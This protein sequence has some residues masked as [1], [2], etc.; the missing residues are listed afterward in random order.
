M[1]TLKKFSNS[2]KDLMS[3]NKQLEM[4]AFLGNHSGTVKADNAG[5]VYVTLF[6]GEVV[7]V[8]NGK[9]PNVPRLPVVIGYLNAQSK[10][11]E[12]LRARDVYVTPA[13]PDVGAHAPLHTFPGADTIPIRGEQFLPGLITPAGGLTVKVYGMAYQI[14]GV[15]YVLTTQEIDLTSEV[16]ASG[17]LMALLQVDDTGTINITAG[18]AVDSRAELGFDDI[19]AGDADQYTLGAVKLYNGQDRILFTVTD[20]DIVDLRWGRGAVDIAAIIHAA[21]EDTSP[22]PDDEFGIWESVSGLLRKVKWSSIITTLGASFVRHSASTASQDFLVG[23][24]TG[25]WIK[26]TFA[27][28]ISI[29]RTSLDSAYAALTHTHAA[30]DVT[31]GTIATA[32]LGS[33]TADATTV[34]HGDQTYKTNLSAK[35]MLLGNALNTTVPASSTYYI[36]PTT[37]VAPNALAFNMA[38]TAACIISGLRFTITAAQP[39]SGSLVIT[40]QKNNVDTAITATIAAGAAA[41]TVTDLTNSVSFA[42]GDLLIIK[43]VNNATAASATISRHSLLATFT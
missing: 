20:T 32:R 21:T 27:E 43:V 26:K 42:A 14:G 16:P 29:L 33:G 30:S 9:V 22:L 37:T 6:N 35:Q 10:R 17:A 1:T 13:Y 24:G 2:L 23:S 36:I 19:P 40:V 38:I 41:G 25:A 18:T 8:Y 11:L 12:I 7:K 28:T 3:V 34:L 39:A 15:W 5:N 4:P 31:S